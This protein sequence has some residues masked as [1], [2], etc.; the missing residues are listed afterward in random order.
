MKIYAM[1]DLHFG[2]GVDKPMDVFGQQWE[3]H[4]E[5]IQENWRRMVGEEDVILLPGD[6]SWAMDLQQAEVDLQRI[7]ALPGKK[8]FIGGNHDYWW[9]STA[10]V[11]ER[12]PNMVFL[13]NESYLLGELGICGTRGWVCPNDTKFTD[14]DRKIYQREQIRLRL[15]LDHAMRKGAKELL[16]M[17]HFPP[18]N[19]KKQESD[20]LKILKEYPVKT[21]V[22]GHLHGKDSFGCGLQ[23]MRDG[24]QYHLVSSDYLAF[25]P[26]LIRE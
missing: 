23:G 16:V 9:A 7:E 15:S 13:K 4:G 2:Y 24:I 14:H 26:R 17:F 12:Y 21:V 10:R 18:T 25:Q 1:G 5:K 22:Y 3:N 19:E 11:Q 6:I 8:I 20:F